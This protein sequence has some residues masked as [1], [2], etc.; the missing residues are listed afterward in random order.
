[1]QGPWMPKPIVQ[2][3]NYFYLNSTRLTRIELRGT[4]R[5]TGATTNMGFAFII[6]SASRQVYAKQGEHFAKLDSRSADR[7][8][9]I[10]DAFAGTM[11]TKE[12]MNWGVSSIGHD[13]VAAHE[14]EVFL[15]TG[16]P[17]MKRKLWIGVKDG[18]VHQAQEGFFTY[19]L[20]NAKINDGLPKELFTAPAQSENV[21]TMSEEQVFSWSGKMRTLKPTPKPLTIFI[22]ARAGNLEAVNGF[23]KADPQLANAKGEDGLT[24]LHQAAIGCHKEVVELLLANKAEIEMKEQFY[25]QATAL[26][27]AAVHGCTDVVRL[28]IA[29]GAK[30]D[31]AT[32]NDRTPLHMAAA[33]GHKDVVELLLANGA[34][35]NAVDKQGWK[36]LDLAVQNGH[37]EVAE[38]LREHG[39]KE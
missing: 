8:L 32:T 11:D 24:P 31:A 5:A 34:D 35:I 36:P 20:R 38:F 7:W 23:L 10:A 18:L 4:V 16:E 22:A 27:F 15:I 13:F 17:S 28:L 26:W 3:M 12:I 25:L 21:P 6:D 2:Q 37:K 39:A 19:E 9:S 30:V 14:T 33:T 29:N 1:M